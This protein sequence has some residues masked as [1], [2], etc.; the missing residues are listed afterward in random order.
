M[1]NS[2]ISLHTIFAVTGG[3]AGLAKKLGISRQAVYKWDEI[4][5]ERMLE[6]EKVTGIPRHQ[7]FPKYFEGYRRVA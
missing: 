7:L 5:M 2:A 4:P 3:R 1:A 6:I